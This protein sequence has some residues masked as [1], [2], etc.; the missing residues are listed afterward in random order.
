MDCKSFLWNLGKSSDLFVVS[1]VKSPAV[2]VLPSTSVV[3]CWNSLSFTILVTK[4]VPL[5]AEFPTPVTFAVLSTLRILIL[6]FNLRSW[7][8]SVLTLIVLPDAEQVLMNLG[9]L[10]KKTSDAVI[11]VWEKSVFALAPVLLDSCKT[12]PSLGSFALAASFGTTTLTVYNL[13]SNDLGST[14]LD[15]NETLLLEES[16]PTPCVENSV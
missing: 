6:S 8:N 12:N 7:G 15:M 10:S 4:N 2:W 9:F 3:E 16:P 13:S 5:N 11:V 14:T 1:L